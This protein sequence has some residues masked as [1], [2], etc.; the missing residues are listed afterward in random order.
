VTDKNK[1]VL[2]ATGPTTIQILAK[3]QAVL[4]E[5]NGRFDLTYP[6]RSHLRFAISPETL[7][8]MRYEVTHGGTGVGLGSDGVLS[9][10]GIKLEKDTGIP[11]G[12]VELRSIVGRSWS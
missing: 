4:R 7:Y 9:I 8:D 3:S 12:E 11:D 2:S 1:M 6:T 5:A 10:W